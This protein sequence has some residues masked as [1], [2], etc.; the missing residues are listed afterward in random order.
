MRTYRRRLDNLTAE[1]LLDGQVSA[2]DAPR[3]FAGT[4]HLLGEARAHFATVAAGS[5]AV[6][7]AM[8]AAI[9]TATALSTT[10]RRKPVLA[11][12]LTAKVAAAAAVLT[13]SATGAAAAT[14][15]LPDA[16]Q[17]GLANAASHVG[18][19]L[20]NSDHGKGS[21]ISTKAKNEET[22]GI[23]KGADVSKTASGGKSHAGDNHPTSSDHPSADDHPAGA[24]SE[25]PPVATPNSG[26]TATASAASGGA[27]ETGTA[28]A[29]PQAAAGSANATDHPTTSSHRTARP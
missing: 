27:S 23:E 28:N 11:K 25:T 1:Q 26:G 15:N 8:V 17:N 3:G 20:P 13:L 5:E 18:I 24:A 2:D 6:V 16:A 22:T 14:G 7:T 4:G 21:E 19:N 10:H 9:E 29:P 12:I